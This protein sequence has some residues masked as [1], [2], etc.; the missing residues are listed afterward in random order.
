MPNH[1]SFLKTRL[2]PT[3]RGYLHLG[4]LASFILTC[5]LA[6]MHGAEILLRIDDLDQH[7]VRKE[8]VQD[9]FDTLDFFELP[10]DQGPRSVEEHF[11]QFSQSYRKKNY[12]NLINELASQNL[13]FAC[14]CSRSMINTSNGESGCSNNCQSKNIPLDKPNVALRLKTSNSSMIELCDLSSG[15]MQYQFPSSMKDFVV[16]KKDGEAAYQIASVSDDLF[17]GVDFIV[18]GQDLIDST[19]AQLFLSAHLSTPNFLSTTFV[20]HP[21]LLSEQDQ[22]LSKSS[23]DTS[24]MHLRKSGMTA[25][26]ILN[27]LGA[28]VC[29]SPEFTNWEE[30]GD[31]L[32]AEWV[33]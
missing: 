5:R 3:P 30:M 23:G 31:C 7:R 11:N 33:N 29:S 4:N 24:V 22:K 8:Y 13:L 32:I 20:H 25:I 16:Q 10:V 19:L 28:C 9:I 15:K 27:E 6:R 12:A 1:L 18:R 21:L 2:A 14:E 26:Q 17:F